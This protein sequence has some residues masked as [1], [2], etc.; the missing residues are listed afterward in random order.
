MCAYPFRYLMARVVLGY[1]IVP[2]GAAS[3]PYFTNAGNR[4]SSQGA[5][6]ARPIIFF[7]LLAFIVNM[8]VMSAD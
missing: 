1:A 8:A 7:M 6:A 5:Q 3:S 2:S 4:F